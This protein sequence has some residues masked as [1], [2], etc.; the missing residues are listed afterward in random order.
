M[1]AESGVQTY[2]TKHKISSLF[3]VLMMQVPMV[4]LTEWLCLRLVKFLM[5]KLLGFDVK[6]GEGIA[7]RSNRFPHKEAASLA[8]TQEEGTG[9][10]CR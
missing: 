6:S 3:E 1:A 7:T 8:E 2:L 5:T 10:F 4:A 9:V